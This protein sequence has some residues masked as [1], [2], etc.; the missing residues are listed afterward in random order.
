MPLIIRLRIGKVLRKRR[1]AHRELRK[2]QPFRRNLG[3]TA[4]GS[5]RD[6]RYPRR[7][8]TPR[9]CRRPPPASPLCA[10][11][12]MPRAIPLTIV[13]PACA[14]SADSRSA[15]A[16]PY[17]VGRRVPTTASD[18]DLQQLDPAP[19]EQHHRRIEDLAQRAADSADRRSRPARRRSPPSSPAGRRRPRTCSRWRSTARPRRSRPPPP[20]RSATRGR[21]PAANGNAPA[22]YSKCGLPDLGRVLRPASEVPLPG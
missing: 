2:D 6:T 12:S 11:V 18:S 9:S 13:S 17:G 7:I 10:A 22:V 20:T 21:S 4:C 14:R 19:R 8:R 5:P 16:T 15:A 1:R 3:R